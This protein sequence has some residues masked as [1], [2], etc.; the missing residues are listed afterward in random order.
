MAESG[1]TKIVHY[2]RDRFLWNLAAANAR[3]NLHVA[4]TVLSRAPEKILAK[5]PHL[6]GTCSWLKGDVQDFAFPQGEFTHIIH[7]ATSVDARFN[8]SEPTAALDTIIG[9]TRRVLDF[10][11]QAGTQ[12]FLLTSSGAVYGPQ[13]STLLRIPEDYPGGPDTTHIDSVYAEGKRVSELL[14]AIAAK[15]TGLNAKIAR[16]FCFTGPHLPLDWHFAIGNFMGDALAG[17][18]LVIK[19][20]G[21]PLRSYMHA[22]DLTVWFLTILLNGASSTL[23]GVAQCPK[24]ACW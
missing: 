4:A 16:C 9:G 23:D 8:A 20:D 17:R 24:G 15:H 7:A 14:L 10:A 2:W 5:C 13:P 21:R 19:G 3:L 1:R 18:E 6:A 11:V 12:N 22:T